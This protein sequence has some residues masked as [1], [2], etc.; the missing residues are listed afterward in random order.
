[1][2][3]RLSILLVLVISFTLSAQTTVITNE[4]EKSSNFE[5][6]LG[7]S[8]S[9][10][11]FGVNL[12]SSINKRFALRL[13]FENVNMSF[14]D[15]FIYKQSGQTLAVT[16]VYKT[17]GLSAI[18]DL[19]LFRWLYLSGGIVY[20]NMNIAA[21]MMSGNSLKIGDIVFQPDELGE[22]VLTVKPEN[23]VAPYGS[24]GFGRNISRNHRLALSFEI[25][26]YYMQS[27]LI[28]MTGT[29]LFEA[30]GDATNQESIN[31]LNESL[32]MISWNGF[33]P[34]IKFGISYKIFGKTKKNRLAKQCNGN[35]VE[36]NIIEAHKQ[37]Q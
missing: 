37:I 26:T 23:K 11:G 36:P 20:S 9:T 33:Y 21:K 12:T 22:L 29:K 30:N 6:S 2:R 25:G 1:M 5:I 13:G 14:N 10:N 31:K 8:V 17:G 28:G 24:I 15:A 18:L 19:Y 34:V 32:K 35:H 16:P 27:Y 7:T 3:K 4:T